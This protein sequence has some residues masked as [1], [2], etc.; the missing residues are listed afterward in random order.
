MSV[1]PGSMNLRTNAHDSGILLTWILSVKLKCISNFHW[2][3]GLLALEVE[4]RRAELQVLEILVQN[5]L[6]TVIVVV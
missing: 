3:E 4:K 6:V 5:D 2:R 1:G